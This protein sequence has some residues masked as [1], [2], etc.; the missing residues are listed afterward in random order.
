MNKVLIIVGSDSDLSKMVDAAKI[1]EGFGVEAETTISSAHRSPEQ[2]RELVDKFQRQG[3]KV[4]ICAAGM[5]A[6]LAGAVAAQFPLPVIGVPI[7]SGILN[8]IDALLSTMQMPPGIPVAT[9]A[10]NGAKNAGIL[11]VQILAASDKSLEEKLIK[12]KQK[13][14]EAVK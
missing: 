13:L 12:Y 3:G 6:H 9:V 7:E 8:G 14:A 5:A 2:T 1:L 10:I 11:A 4:I